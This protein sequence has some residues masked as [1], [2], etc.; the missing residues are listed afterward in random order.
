MLNK[1]VLNI[2]YISLME[3]VVKSVF[4]Y[5]LTVIYKCRTVNLIHCLLKL[6]LAEGRYTA[7][8]FLKR[9]TNAIADSTIPADKKNIAG[10]VTA[11]R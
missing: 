6:Q 5:W 11:L 7:P 9:Q 10:N 3:M 1:Q 2:F 4:K 8:F